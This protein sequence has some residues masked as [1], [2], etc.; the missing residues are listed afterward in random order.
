MAKTVVDQLVA[1]ADAAADAA[2]IHG[3]DRTPFML[4]HIAAHSQGA[5]VRLNGA[6]VLANARLAGEIAIELAPLAWSKEPKDLDRFN[7]IDRSHKT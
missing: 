7:D 2:G 6:L 4:R 1:H 5:T 3:P